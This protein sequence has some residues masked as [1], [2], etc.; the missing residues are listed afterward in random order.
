M[1]ADN[2]S[3]E[4]G[5]HQAYQQLSKE[6][7]SLPNRLL[8]ERAN[9]IEDVGQR[10]M[11]ILTGKLDEEDIKS[12]IPDGSIVVS[13]NITPSLLSSLPLDKIA[14]FCSVTGGSTSHISIIA[15]SLNIPSIV[16]L[17]SDIL[18]IPNQTKVSIDGKK[19]EFRVDVSDDT[20]DKIL[21]KKEELSIE[22]ANYLENS[23]QSATT[24]DGREIKI[25]ANIASE[26]D[27]KK[28]LSYGAEGVGLFRSEYIFID[29]DSAPTEEEQYRI[30]SNIAL[31]FEQK[32]I[33]I[34]TLDVGGDKP[35]SYISLPKEDNPFLGIRGIRVSFRNI[36]LFRSQICAILR[37]SINGNVSLM[38][39]MISTIDE[40]RE[41]KSIVIEERKSL[42]IDYIP[43]G[44]MVEVPSVAI[45]AD[46]FAKEVDFFSIGTNDLTQYT[47]ATDRGHTE[48]SKKVDSLDLSI[49]HMIKYI[50]ESAHNEKIKVSICGA[51]ASNPI[52]TPLLVGLGVD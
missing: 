7:S 36:E 33:T 52:A 45:L 4:H 37:A 21:R 13:N 49:I 32:P 41:L 38:F 40:I 2:K 25:L 47:L 8:A 1:I 31:A 6:I 26:D 28:A 19:G 15:R 46:K 42:N 27:I 12:H 51:L 9:D 20:I 16:A 3:A 29:R 39:P 17:S 34:R 35:I 24:I 50:T 14:G 11:K 22:T 23:K 18:D 30:Y 44:I 10:V 43:I 48:L 5:W